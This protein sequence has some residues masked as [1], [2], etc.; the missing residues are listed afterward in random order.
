MPRGEVAPKALQRLA[1]IEVKAIRPAKA[2]KP[3]AFIC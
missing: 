3:Q 2:M 1:S